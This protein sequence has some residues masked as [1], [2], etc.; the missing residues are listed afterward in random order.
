[1][2]I[3]II[4]YGMGNLKSV[5][6]ALKYLGYTSF[7]S[8]DIKEL[9]KADKLILPGVGAF[10]DAIALIREK[11][12]ENFLHQIHHEEVPLLGICLGMQLVFDSS[13]EFGSHKGLSLL[14]GEIVKL[15]VD[16]KIPHMGWNKLN[17]KKE[18]PLFVGLPENSYVYFVHSFHLQT[19]E[20]IVSATT[21][22]GKEIQI[23]VQEKN[24]FALQFHPEKSGD[25]GLQI[26]KNFSSL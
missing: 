9:S 7:V 25:V 17:I 16:L 5:S 11:N 8:S 26:L 1:M 10:K 2:K 13:T 14:K 22:Y 21:Y 18:A 23:A 19:N 6:N 3:G 12:I 15:E 24:T 4:D 20:D